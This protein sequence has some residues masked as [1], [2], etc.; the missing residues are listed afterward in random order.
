[1]E[2]Q[3]TALYNYHKNLG[4]KFVPFAGYEMPI[5]YSDGI[6]K[7]HI[8]TR[9]FA[10]FFDV[11]HMGQFFLEG[12]LTLDNA[13][14]KII[15]ADLSLLKLNQS[16]YSFLLND[17]GGIIDDLIITRTDKGFCIILNA[18]C[19]ENDIKQISKYLNSEHKNYLNT[20]LSLIAL[21]GPKAVTILEKIIPNVSNLKFMNGNNFKFNEVTI[22]ITRS[23][24]TGEDGF[25]ISIPNNQVEK[26][27]KIFV[28]NKVKPIG[29]G[30]RDTLR[31]EAG[32][33]LYGH[34]LNE[35]INPIEA[36]LKWAIAKKRREEGGFNGW[37]KIK[38]ILDNGCSKIR[39]GILPEGR[40]IARE[41]TK[42]FSIE[43]KEIGK[44]TSGTF[45]PSVNASVAM[46]YISLDYSGV[47]NK[48]KIEVRGKKYDAKISKLPF[49]K[50][51]YVK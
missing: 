35:E 50:K 48:I 30:A 12:D 47:G 14:E 46:G 28:S 31:L 1:M 8:S 33:C 6:V 5:Q 25:E 42:I 21:Q 19:K 49:Y 15:P 41:G 45:G 11:S 29:L 32:L 26:L 39:V 4:A 34:D 10:G 27:T 51:S 40:I 38:N 43:D 24:Y 36:N 16:K 18:A 23:G 13:L 2:V 20:D 9:T 17:N 3:K 44:I 22:Y 37:E 7:E